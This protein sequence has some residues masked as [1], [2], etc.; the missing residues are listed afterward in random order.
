MNSRRKTVAAFA[1]AF[2]IVGRFSLPSMR[3]LKTLSL[4]VGSILCLI[5]AIILIGDGLFLWHYGVGFSDAAFVT[6]DGQVADWPTGERPAWAYLPAATYSLWFFLLGA[7]AFS[8]SPEIGKEYRGRV[9][10]GTE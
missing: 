8:V 6:S 10:R 5:G 9:C 2:V 7:T 4:V 3:L 1:S